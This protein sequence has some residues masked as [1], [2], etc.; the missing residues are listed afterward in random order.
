MSLG[1]GTGGGFRGPVCA[2]NS[3][4]T[5]TWYRVFQLLVIGANLWLVTASP[6]PLVSALF[7]VLVTFSL[8]F[9]LGAE[10]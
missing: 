3:W 5:S 9:S 4:Q 1:P 10:P 2:V 7:A 8:G 6:F